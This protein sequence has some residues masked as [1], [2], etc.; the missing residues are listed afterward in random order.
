MSPIA[1]T[2]LLASV[3]GGADSARADGFVLG[4]AVVVGSLGALADDDGEPV[5]DPPPDLPSPFGAPE[6]FVVLALGD[7]EDTGSRGVG[8]TAGGAAR[9]PPWC[10]ANATYP[11]AGTLSPLTPSEAYFQVPVLPSDHHRLQ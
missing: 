2:L 1:G 11:P 8:V 3:G 5:G 10:H 7:G 9:P 4:D 6:P